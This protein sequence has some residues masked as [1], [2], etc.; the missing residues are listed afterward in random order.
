MQADDERNAAKVMCHTSVMRK[1]FGTSEDEL[2]A[3]S[4]FQST[5]RGIRGSGR[6]VFRSTTDP[7]GNSAVIYSLTTES[8]SGIGITG[9]FVDITTFEISN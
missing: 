7:A 1:I 8:G 5:Q 3:F 9:E 6:S 2:A 4:E